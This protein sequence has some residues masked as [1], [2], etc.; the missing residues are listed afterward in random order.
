MEDKTNNERRGGGLPLEIERKYL[1]A[2]P[3]LAA[4]EANP[5]CV[6]VDIVQ[7]YLKTAHPGESLRVR[8]WESG[9]QCRHIRTYKRKITGMTRIEL[10]EDIAPEA[11]QALLAQ[12]DPDC[13]PIVKRRY[14]VS[15]N[16][17]L[18]EIDVYPEWTDRAVLEI[19]LESEAQVVVL[20]DWVTVLREV[21]E[22][23][24]YTN[25]AL[26]RRDQPWPD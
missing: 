19:E 11:Y 26:A 12:A 8:R 7:T 23:P 15:E 24:R 10:E 3:D 16:G 6:R 21:T 13:R 22:D 20:P 1:I 9:G 4:L 14:R 17:L 5:N 18:Y 25:H 2:Y